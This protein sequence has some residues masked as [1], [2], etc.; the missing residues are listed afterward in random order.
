MKSPISPY[1]PV[2][3]R[4]LHNASGLLIFSALITGYIIYDR[5]DKRWGTLN[6]PTF[7]DPQG[8][9]GTIAITFLILLPIFALYCFHVGDRYL[10]QKE[11]LSHLKNINKPIWW[12]SLQRLTNTLTL[13]SA[14]LAV[15]TGRMM[16]EDWLPN[17]ELNHAWYIG[18][19]LSWLLMIVSIASHLLMSIKIGGLPL[20]LS[21]MKWQVQTKDI[22]K[23]WFR[24]FKIKPS[25]TILFIFEFFVIGGIAIAFFLPLISQN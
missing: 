22:P 12:I 19:L 2:L 15:V 18:H 13:V 9:H 14:T 3:L 4:L 20:I 21:M 11:S 10:V 17:Q 8:L 24:K 6:L 7:R 5:Y 1:Q 25:S 23:S 16:K